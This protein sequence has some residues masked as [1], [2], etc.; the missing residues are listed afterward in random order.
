MTKAQAEQV[1][2]VIKEVTI[3]QIGEAYIAH[4]ESQFVARRAY[5]VARTRGEVTLSKHGVTW[6]VL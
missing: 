3:T 5:E 1:K 4:T 2:S 6:V